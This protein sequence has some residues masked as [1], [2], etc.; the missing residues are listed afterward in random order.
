ME[1]EVTLYTNKEYTEALKKRLKKLKIG[2]AELGRAMDP[3]RHK[4]QVSRWFTE[5]PERRVKPTME[6]VLE[7]E[8]AIQRIVA[9]RER[10]AKKS[11][12]GAPMSE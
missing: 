1:V 8:R 4:T 9:K 10:A 2:N 6:T 5:T 12:G 11:T 7:M 3:P